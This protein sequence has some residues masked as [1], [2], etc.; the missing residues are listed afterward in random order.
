MLI[1][2]FKNY[3]CSS[4]LNRIG[5]Y[6]NIP[7]QSAII[8]WQKNLFLSRKTVDNRRKQNILNSNIFFMKE[9]EIRWNKNIVNFIVLLF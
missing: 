4:M 7:L 9:T 5:E 2:T 3:H 8:D 1:L 6:I